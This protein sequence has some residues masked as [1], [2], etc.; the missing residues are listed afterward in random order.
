M[1]KN[2]INLCRGRQGGVEL[3]VTFVPISIRSLLDA[4]GGDMK[5]KKPRFN[6]D[7]IIFYKEFSTGVSD[8]QIYFNRLNESIGEN[9]ALEIAKFTWMFLN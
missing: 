2:Y 3:E 1:L 6:D 5:Y 9:Q 4:V 7:T 8:I